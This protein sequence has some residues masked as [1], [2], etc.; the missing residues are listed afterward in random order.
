MNSSSALEQ[1]IFDVLSKDDK[2]HVEIEK[3]LNHFLSTGSDARD[4]ENMKKAWARADIESKAFGQKKIVP[5]EFSKSLVRE[6]TSK[7]KELEEM[8]NKTKKVLLE[9]TIERE[10]NLPDLLSSQMIVLKTQLEIEKAKPRVW[11]D[12]VKE[13]IDTLGDLDENAL[14]MKR[15]TR[16]SITIVYNQYEFNDPN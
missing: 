2:E 15:N 1:I 14:L 13:R 10:W 5:T 8:N 12:R 6:L 4:C 7:Y 3:L 11:N 16:V 9:S